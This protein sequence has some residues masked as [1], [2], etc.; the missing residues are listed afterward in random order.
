[1][2]LAKKAVS[3]KKSGQVQ[4]VKREK[5]SIAKE[6]KIKNKEKAFDEFDLETEQLIQMTNKNRIKKEE[7]ITKQKEIKEKKRQKRNKRVKL[8]FKLF[9]FIIL[10]GGA[11]IFAMTSPIF[12]IKEIKVT[13]NTHVP[14]DTIIS[15]SKIKID[16]NIFKFYKRDA[17]NNIKGNAY[18]E[19]VDIERKIPNTVEIK[20]EERIPKYSVDFM[21]KFMYINS[22]G[23]FLELSEDN[24]N[25][26][27][28]HGITTEEE[29]V[30]PG[31]RLNNEDLTRLEE[32]M[33]I[34]SSANENGLEGKV[35]SVDISNKN[36]YT[37][38]LEEKKK[39][40]HIGNTSN[41]SNKMLYVLAIME[42]EEGKEGDIYVNGD[43]NNKFQPYFREKV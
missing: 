39:K 20:V 15:L 30:I 35:T 25:L 21:G 1:M 32:V 23:Y 42:Q 7:R 4:N 28:I 36:D 40:I 6:K 13:N 8:F 10:I 27:I 38:Y 34:M 12:N 2:G 22:Q 9:L 37:I 16:E 17:S 29:K 24:K 41:L 19:N 11:I 33:K 3:K 14:S 31:N 5:K 43:L 26:T 18:I